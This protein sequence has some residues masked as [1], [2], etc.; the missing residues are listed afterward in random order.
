MIK[1][2]MWLVLESMATADPSVQ[3]SKVSL[4]FLFNSDDTNTITLNENQRRIH[5][6]N[7][8]RNGAK[9]NNSSQLSRQRGL[10]SIH[11][12][13]SFGR[14]RGGAFETLLAR[15][16]RINRSLLQRRHHTGWDKLHSPTCR[17]GNNF[18]NGTK[19]ASLFYLWKDKLSYLENS[20][21]FFRIII[22]CWNWF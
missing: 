17:S 1:E 2:N 14:S 8:F 15:G 19:K 13:F 5:F 3:P 12:M 22:C 11:P 16:W 18:N 4:I 6:S 21:A 20:Q 9:C 7:I 10:S